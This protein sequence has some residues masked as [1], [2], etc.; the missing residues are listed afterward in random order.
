MAH[1]T[2]DRSFRLPIDIRPAFYDAT[3]TVD[4]DNKVFAGSMRLSLVLARASEE[5]VL[6]AAGLDVSRVQL[7]AGGTKIAAQVRVVPVSETLVLRFPA[8]VKAGEAF[9]HLDWSGKISQGLQGLYVAGPRIAATQFEPTDARRVFP[10][11]DEPSFKAPW[12]LE[13]EAAKDLVVLSNGAPVREEDRG[14]KRRVYFAQTPPLPSYLVALVVGPI[15][16]HSPASVRNVPVRTFAQPEKLAL[17]DFGQDVAVEVLG[18]LEDY[19]GIPYAFGKLDQVGLPEF[20]MGAMENAGLITYRETA[21]LL[22][23]ATASLAQKKRISE[24]VTHELAHQWFGNW[25]TMSWWDDLW[26]NESF[27]TW[28][29]YK[30]VNEWKPGWR[31]WLDFDQGKAAAMHLD[32][33]RSTHP[34]HA[35]I[36]TV[37]EAEE[38]FDLITYNKGGAV[39]RMIENYLGAAPF[40]EGIRLYMRRHGKANAV[41]NDLWTALGEASRE[42]V[43]E[44]A[45]AWIHKTGFPLVRVARTGRVL[46]LEQQRFFSNPAAA[47][48]EEVSTWPVPLV[49][50]YGDGER[51]SEQRFLLRERKVELSLPGRDE[52][53]FIFANAGGTGFYRVAYDAAGLEALGRH[54]GRLEISERIALLSDEWALVRANEREITSFLDLAARFGREE[55]YAVL[56]ELVGRLSAVEYR[57]VAD[58]DRPALRRWVAAM[59]T[60]QLSVTGWDPANSEPDAVRLRRAAAVQALGLIA[61]VSEVIGEARA[62]LDRWLAG[63]RSALEANLHDAAVAMVARTG[64]QARF[65]QFQSLFKKENEPTFR[66]RYLLAL[67]SFEDPK[68]AARGLDYGF[69]DQVPLQDWSSFISVL[70]TNPTAREPA[71][72]RLR[73]E[74]EAVRA[75]LTGAPAL[76]RRLI[77]AFGALIERRHLGEVEAFLA[78]HRIEEARQTVAQT[79]ERLRQD[80][81]LRERTQP[82]I[83]QWLASA[84]RNT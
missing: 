44:L 76:F 84:T 50:R 67:A 68:L 1:P 21:L 36:R 70:L 69:S 59:F 54:L 3:L 8:P 82:L 55:D 65:E 60:P 57:L 6:H 40:R 41:A 51:T 17:T 71:W 2:E 64:D 39:L 23:P 33:L 32:A 66:R 58:R 49:I 35:E 16:P 74:W 7:E 83:G 27:A 25:V 53:A 78:A 73:A 28:M 30:I 10:C 24:V 4:V 46:R 13:I 81:E 26:L 63:D 9:L 34:I 15:A 12:R 5:I 43:L 79:L 47:R 18:R 75:R 37:A 48:E 45:N 31:V 38:A 19:F 11:F 14:N 22:D 80:V 20:Q 62:R 61:R 72:A 29:A 42:P 52:P 77:E 56:D